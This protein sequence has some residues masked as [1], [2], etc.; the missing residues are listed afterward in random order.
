MK[1]KERDSKKMGDNRNYISEDV[2]I[3]V[4]KSAIHEHYIEED[5]REK[6][7]FILDIL[8]VIAVFLV[9]GSFVYYYWQTPP[10]GN[11]A[12][13]GA[14]QQVGDNNQNKGVE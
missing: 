1:F 11:Y 2:T 4:L 5:K 6:R 9:V 13:N 3:E 10:I 8:K 12:D 7:R 14:V